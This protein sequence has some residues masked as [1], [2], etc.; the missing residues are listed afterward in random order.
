MWYLFFSF[1]PMTLRMANIYFTL[2]LSIFAGSLLV[3]VMPFMI[4]DTGAS[5]FFTGLSL[6]LYYVG[7]LA[8][9][10][11]FWRLSDKIWRQKTLFLT[12]GLDI[13]GYVLLYFFHSLHGLLLARL[14]L[15]FWGSTFPIGQAYLSDLST[16]E[17]K[18]KNMA[19]TGAIF[20]IAFIVWPSLGS[21]LYDWFWMTMLLFS[22]TLLIINLISVSFLKDVHRPHPEEKIEPS[23][24]WHFPKQVYLFFVLSFFLGLSMSN[25]QTTFPLI[26]KDVYQVGEKHIGYFLAYVWITSVVYQWFLMKYV[27]KFLNERQMILIWATLLWC[28]YLG[29]A[30]NSWYPLIFILVPLTPLGM[31][32]TNPAIAGLTSRNSGKFTGKALGTLSSSNSLWALI[33]GSLS[34]YLYTFSPFYPNFVSSLACFMLVVFAWFWVKKMKSHHVIPHQSDASLSH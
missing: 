28:S 26:L 16:P 33:W 10:I 31:G 8:G 9:W 23:D 17:E 34:G 22:L 4:R 18:T 1:S 20:G 2:F 12:V 5:D 32:T 25:M 27:R 29:Y 15:W 21:L 13:I 24:F 19:F 7:M 14:F 30:L 3:P 11:F 6:S